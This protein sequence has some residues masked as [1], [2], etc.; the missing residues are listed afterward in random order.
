MFVY[1][2]K[3]RL[4]RNKYAV[5]KFVTSRQDDCDKQYEQQLTVNSNVKRK[6][7][8]KTALARYMLALIKK[9]LFQ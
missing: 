7:N 8:K 4:S 6:Y 5:H 1:S 2:I 9:Y 3:I